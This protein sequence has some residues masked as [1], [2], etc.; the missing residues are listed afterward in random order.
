MSLPSRTQKGSRPC[1]WIASLLLLTVFFLPLHL[2][3]FTSTA[4]VNKECGCYY[5][6]R[7]QADLARA[8][9]NFTPT[10]QVSSVVVYEP[11]VFAWSSFDSYAIRAPP[12][13]TSL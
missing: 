12:S 3:F 9:A 13:I 7:T 2:H 1:H 11:Q 4:Q 5:G 8:P 10:F 6:G